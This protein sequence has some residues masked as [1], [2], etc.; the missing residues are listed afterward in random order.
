MF[1]LGWNE[2]CYFHGNAETY[3]TL[4][5]LSQR[6]ETNIFMTHYRGD[7]TAAG[8]LAIVTTN[9]AV[10]SCSGAVSSPFYE[11][12]HN[13]SREDFDWYANQ[14]SS[15]AV[16][17]EED[18]FLPQYVS[19]AIKNLPNLLRNVANEVGG[20]FAM[21]D[22]KIHDDI[23]C[24]KEECCNRL[25]TQATDYILPTTVWNTKTNQDKWWS[26]GKFGF[27]INERDRTNLI[28]ELMPFLRRIGILENAAEFAELKAKEENK[29]NDNENETNSSSSTR[30]RRSTRQMAARPLRWQA[31]AARRHH[32]FDKLSL[33]LRRDEADLN[34]SEVGE[35]FAND[36]IV[37]NK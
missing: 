17:S 6:R 20:G 37:Y 32:Y 3:M 31:K 36:S 21:M 13:D 33:T 25:A 28:L 9:T 34:S 8:Q 15:R 10:G 5:S 11:D 19:P 27:A 29:N 2:N 14:E 12:I 35:L 30:P 16:S 1:E 4:P 22:H 7:E 23:E 18:C 26:Y 24:R